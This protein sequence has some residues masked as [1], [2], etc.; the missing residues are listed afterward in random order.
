MT[1]CPP[2]CLWFPDGCEVVG[3]GP[4]PVES[5]KVRGRSPWKAV[6]CEADARGK[7]YGARPKPVESSKVPGRS[8]WKAVKCEAEARGKQ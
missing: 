6:R 4:R 1:L 7:Q 8:P 5:S 2:I 3:E